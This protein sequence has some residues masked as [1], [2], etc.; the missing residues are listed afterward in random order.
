MPVK[1][2]TPPASW[3]ASSRTNPFKQMAMAWCEQAMAWPGPRNISAPVTA[4]AKP[5]IARMDAPAGPHRG[6]LEAFAGELT[7]AAAVACRAA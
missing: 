2:M 3:V 6:P 1:A 4:V 7:G 5:A